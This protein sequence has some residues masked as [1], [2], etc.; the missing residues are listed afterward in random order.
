MATMWRCCSHVL[1]RREEALLLPPLIP[2]W[3]HVFWTVRGWERQAGVYR[4]KHV[5]SHTWT[6]PPPRAHQAPHPSWLLPMNGQSRQ[7]SASGSISGLRLQTSAETTCFCA[8]T[9]PP[10]AR[11]PASWQTGPCSTASGF[12]S[13]KARTRSLWMEGG[14]S[15]PA[16]ISLPCQHGLLPLSPAPLFLSFGPLWIRL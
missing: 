2:A 5:L 4:D 10:G 3:L 1:L 9:L 6:Q 11:R 15:L 8:G 13:L 16:Y 12:T 14:L 7:F